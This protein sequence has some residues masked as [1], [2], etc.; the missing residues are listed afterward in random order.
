MA[1]RFIRPKHTR[2][3][4]ARLTLAVVALHAALLL[5]FWL[6]PTDPPR[7]GTFMQLMW[8]SARRPSFLVL[9]VVAIAAPTLTIL[10]W[11]VRGVH[12]R[13]LVISWGVFLFFA[14]WHYT[15]RLLVMMR[16][17]YEQT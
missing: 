11:P 15:H 5:T 14:G 10:A 16:I 9:A 13:W 12:R 17:L 1:R 8:A 4:A 2:R 3:V 7:Q 6:D